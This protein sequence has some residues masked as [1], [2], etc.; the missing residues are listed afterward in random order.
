M[1]GINDP[2]PRELVSRRALEAR[3]RRA[4]RRGSEGKVDLKRTRGARARADLGEYYTLD[5]RRNVI[6][7]MRV[8]LERLGR[9]LGVL[10]PYEGFARKAA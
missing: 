2:A 1:D 5:V 7:S 6:L 4:I 9:D 8:D 10:A 3:I